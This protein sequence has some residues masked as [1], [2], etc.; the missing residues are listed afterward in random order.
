MST[1][2]ETLFRSCPRGKHSNAKINDST[3]GRSKSRTSQCKGLQDGTLCQVLEKR[4]HVLYMAPGSDSHQSVR[5][6]GKLVRDLVA[7][8][9][10][11]DLPQ[12]DPEAL[13]M[14]VLTF[15]TQLFR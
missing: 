9:P 12:L 4:F 14:F 7:R 2:T 5:D 11:E 3:G 1:V 6:K 15:S 10:F 13:N 8:T